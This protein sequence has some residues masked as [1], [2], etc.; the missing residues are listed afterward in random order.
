MTLCKTNA[1]EDWYLEPIKLLVIKGDRK[2]CDS[3]KDRKHAVE[4]S[5]VDRIG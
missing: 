4:C 5:F 2:E 3:K 1:P